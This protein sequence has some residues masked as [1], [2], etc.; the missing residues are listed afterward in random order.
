MDNFIFILLSRPLFTA[1]NNV[2]MQ[3]GI[4]GLKLEKDKV[5]II[6]LSDVVGHGMYM[7]LNF[8]CEK[9]WVQTLLLNP[10]FHLRFLDKKISN[11]NHSFEA[12]H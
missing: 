2:G 6:Y 8:Y 12:R 1:L 10:T 9:P 3:N 7:Y 4:L 11:V 5:D